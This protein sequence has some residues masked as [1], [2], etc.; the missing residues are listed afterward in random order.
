MNRNHADGYAFPSME[1][2][3][4]FQTFQQHP[5]MTVL[6]YF[7]AAAM[8]GILAS[9]G[10]VGTF[11]NILDGMVQSREKLARGRTRLA[12]AAYAIAECMLNEKTNR[13]LAQADD[14]A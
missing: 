12:Q 13:Y 1:M 2:L 4:E 8:Q 7:A 9:S 10:S 3:G 6:D 14:E 11:G 5:G